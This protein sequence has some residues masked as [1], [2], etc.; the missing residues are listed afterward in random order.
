MPSSTFSSSDPIPAGPWTLTWLLAAVLAVVA[1]GSSE[2]FWRA[3]GVRPSI[4]DDPEFWSYWRG[5]AHVGGKRSVILIGASRIQTDFHTP[6][7]HV[8]FPDYR[9]TQLAVPGAPPVAAL[10]DVAEDD[11]ICGLVICSAMSGWLRKQNWSAQQ[12]YVDHYHHYSTLNSRCNRLLA[13]WIQ[14]RLVAIHPAVNL[15][16]V[17]VGLLKT[18]RLPSPPRHTFH[19]DRSRSIDFSRVDIAEL[20]ASELAESIRSSGTGPRYRPDRFR[21]DL[22]ILRSFVRKIEARGGK[23]V[24]VRFPTSGERVAIDENRWPKSVYWDQI[25]PVTSAE[26]IHYADVPSLRR[27]ECPDMSHLDHR[28]SP[29]FTNA[30]LD[31][32]VRRGLLQDERLPSG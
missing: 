1:L 6:T 31:E 2:A 3:R 29:K 9:L 19:F 32:L 10:R 28:D 14:A 4:V 25:G 26:T 12:E 30:F 15:R 22:L 23:V 18:G 7:F 17:V 13:C 8:R 24:F 11:R 20:R 21:A 27:F 16:S 5:M